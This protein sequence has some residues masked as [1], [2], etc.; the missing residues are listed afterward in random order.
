MSEPLVSPV[1]LA[2]AHYRGPSGDIT[3]K[4]VMLAWVTCEAFPEGIPVAI[5]TGEH[6]HRHPYPGDGG[7]HF[8][9]IGP[10]T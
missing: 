6:D 4:G 1:C 8:E 3:G 7:I 5:T 9:T 10:N 2:C